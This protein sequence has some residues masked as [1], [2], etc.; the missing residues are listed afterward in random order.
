VKT[1]C[2]QERRER[3]GIGGGECYR[4]EYSG[5]GEPVSWSRLGKGRRPEQLRC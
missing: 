1:E 2:W 5:G 4:K 3:G